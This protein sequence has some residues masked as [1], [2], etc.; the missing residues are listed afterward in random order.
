MA[1]TIKVGKVN[2]QSLLREIRSS[3]ARQGKRGQLSYGLEESRKTHLQQVGEIAQ[4][5]RAY[6]TTA[7]QSI[8]RELRDPQFSSNGGAPVGELRFLASIPK[9]KYLP[10]RTEIVSVSQRWKG[11]FWRYKQ[12]RN[13]SRKFWRK[14]G[15][16]SVL[17]DA[18]L[19]DLYPKLKRQGSYLRA[20]TKQEWLA[21]F[22]KIVLGTGDQSYSQYKSVTF[23]RYLHFPVLPEPLDIL[24]MRPFALNKVRSRVAT[25]AELMESFALLRA[26]DPRPVPITPVSLHR[27]R[28]AEGQ[29]P[30]I[31]NFSRQ[32]GQ[33]L[34]SHAL[35]QL[36]SVYA[37]RR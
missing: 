11:L 18:T 10:A 29:R 12:R 1:T 6:Y 9:S 32:M 7:I 22:N 27:I 33:R 25:R 20:V 16:S 37:S 34:V 19:R 13:R 28:L 2:Q 15:T 36:K 23:K 26:T 5:A 31:Q 4:A 3:I 21:G 17:F 8:G 35:Q 14:T 30:W 24:V